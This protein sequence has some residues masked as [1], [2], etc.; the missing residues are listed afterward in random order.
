LAEGSE[1]DADDVDSED[2]SDDVDA[3]SGASLFADVGLLLLASDVSLAGVGDDAGDG[4][5]D[6]LVAAGV[7]VVGLVVVDVTGGGVLVEGAT[8]GAAGATLVS[9]V[10][11]ETGSGARVWVGASTV[12][13]TVGTTTGGGASTVCCTVGTTT[14]A[15]A[16]GDGM[17]A[18]V[19]FSTGASVTVTGGAGTIVVVGTTGSSPGLA[20][21][22]AMPPVSA[23]MEMTTPDASTAQTVR[24]R[25]NSNG[26]PIVHRLLCSQGAWRLLDHSCHAQP[27]P[28]HWS[29]TSSCRGALPLDQS[30]VPPFRYSAGGVKIQGT[31]RRGWA[32]GTAASSVRV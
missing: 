23:V 10:V 4:G 3:G 2:V 32:G 28:Q 22:G 13:C 19:G 6:P 5:V 11:G 21:A 8:R 18:T 29:Q 31:L 14:G 24:L 27:S 25:Q 20:N 1:V 12:C 7:D 26:A 16:T 9:A 17:S 30:A 15:G